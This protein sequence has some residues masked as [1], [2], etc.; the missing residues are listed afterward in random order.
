L[1]SL[2]GMHFL[3]G[4]AGCGASSWCYRFGSAHGKDGGFLRALLLRHRCANAI[5]IGGCFVAFLDGFKWDG[6]NYLGC[7]LLS[8][9]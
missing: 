4:R 6:A 7:G 1:V 5:F 9:V 3:S 8:L 2:A